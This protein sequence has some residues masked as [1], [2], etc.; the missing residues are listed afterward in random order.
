MKEMSLYL[1]GVVTQ[2][3]W[4]GSPTQHPIFVQAI[5]RTQAILEFMMY[6]RYDS[7]DDHTLSYM[8]DTFCDF[9]TFKVVF[10]L[11]RAGK[12][13]QAKSNALRT[14]LVKTWMV[15]E[16]THADTWK[17][18]NKLCKL[19]PWWNNNSYEIDNSTGL[20]EDFNF[21]K[22]HIMSDWVEQIRW[23]GALQQYSAKRHEQ[24]HKTKLKDGWNSSNQ[25]LNYLPQVINYQC[26]ILFSEIWEL[27]LKT[28]ERHEEDSTPTCKV[29]PSGADLAALRS[30]QS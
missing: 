20:D 5:E 9:P 18:S 26:H 3:L 16:E 15:D 24:A 22:F 4:G 12:K 13:A 1:L 27:N 14:E 17:L 11:G 8:D 23:Y 2:F 6:A 25:I 10:L 28:L 30:S 29:L 21:P 7:H 19:N